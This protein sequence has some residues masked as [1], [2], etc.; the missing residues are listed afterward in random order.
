VL[1]SLHPGSARSV[2]CLQ[3]TE[4]GHSRGET[5]MRAEKRFR[6]RVEFF[7]DFGPGFRKRQGTAPLPRLRVPGRPEIPPPP[8]LLPR[9]SD[10]PLPGGERSKDR[11]GAPEDRATP[12]LPQ[13]GQSRLQREHVFPSIGEGRDRGCRDAKGGEPIP[14][15][16]WL[17]RGQGPGTCGLTSGRTSRLAP[18][19]TPRP[20]RFPPGSQTACGAPPPSSSQPRP[21]VVR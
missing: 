5:G 10:V 20:T 2:P 18:Q 7:P 4:M 19:L 21:D 17:I 13:P 3:P 8:C 12:Q 11:V 16:E 1:R 15:G 9:G 6:M 14:D